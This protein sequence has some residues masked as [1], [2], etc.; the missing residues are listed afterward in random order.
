MSNVVDRTL[1]AELAAR[2]SKAACSNFAARNAKCPGLERLLE[3]ER[4]PALEA[5]NGEVSI[6][7]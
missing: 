7:L 2:H 1:R 5:P 6:S 4:L 3:G